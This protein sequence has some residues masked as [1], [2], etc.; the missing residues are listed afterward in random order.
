LLADARVRYVIKAD[1]ETN[2]IVKPIVEFSAGAE[3]A[4]GT[5]VYASAMAEIPNRG[6]RSDYPFAREIDIK[7][8]ATIAVK[9]AFAG[10]HTPTNGV[11]IHNRSP[12]RY[13]LNANPVTPE[14][15]FLLSGSTSNA[16]PPSATHGGSA[17]EPKVTCA[18]ALRGVADARAEFAPAEVN[19]SR[20]A[21]LGHR[22]Y[23]TSVMVRCRSDTIG[24]REKFDDAAA[25][26]ARVR[27][28]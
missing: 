9:G 15:G 25:P 22:Y 8:E 23:F 26:A 13:S 21:S 2:Q 1:P 10:A 7:P 27:A 16:P 18:T 20:I 6:G 17:G 19:A 28:P 12:R 4:V 3:L 14:P 11:T 5:E 24:D